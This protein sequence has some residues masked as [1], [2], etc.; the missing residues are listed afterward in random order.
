[1]FFFSWCLDSYD[2]LGGTLQAATTSRTAPALASPLNFHDVSVLFILCERNRAL[3]ADGALP[4]AGNYRCRGGS[5]NVLRDA[6]GAVALAF[7]LTKSLSFLFW[8]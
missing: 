4:A 3:G 5:D 2:S 1:M 8:K 7:V 6:L